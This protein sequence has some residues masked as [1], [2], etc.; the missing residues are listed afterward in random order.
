[1]AWSVRRDDIQFGWQSP[2]HAL[3][4]RAHSWLPV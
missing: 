2:D 1:V 3:P 4:V